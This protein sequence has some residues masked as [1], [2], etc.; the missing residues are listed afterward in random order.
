MNFKLRGPIN[1][2]LT[3]EEQI[4]MNR[5]VPV[6]KMKKLLNT[7]DNDIN[8]PLLFGKE[9]MAVAAKRIISAIVNN[10]DTLIIVDADCDGYTSAAIL[11]N[12][13]HDLAPVWTENHIKWFIHSGKQHGMGDVDLNLYDV[14]LIL[15]PDAGSNDYEHHADA[16]ARGM[17]VIILDHH[18]AEKI[19]D[20]AIVINNQLSDYPNKELSGAGVTWQFC[21]YIDSINNT[22]FAKDYIDLCALGNCADMMSMQSIETKHLILS[23]FRLDNIKNPF[24]FEMAKK[25]AHSLG[26]HITPIGAAFYI[27]PFI[28]AMVRSGEADEKEMLFQSMLKFKAFTQIP[29]GKRGC[30]GQMARLVD[31]AVRIATNVK[32][33]QTRNETAGMDLVE[34]LIEKNDMMAHK[35]LLFLLKPGDIDKNIAGLVANKIMA[36]Y[37]RPCCMLT[38][39]GDT[40]AGSARGCDA[41]DVTN[42]KD[43]CESTGLT[44]YAQGHQGAF[45]ISLDIANINNFVNSTDEILKDMP[46]EPV[47][48]VD[49]LYDQNNV[50]T[51]AIAKISA[52][53]DIWGR[54]L[55]ESYVG[56]QEIKLEPSMVTM[57]AR[58]TMK[59]SLP[60]ITLIQF[61]TKEE[62]YNELTRSGV[63]I[64]VYGKP[65]INEYNGRVYPQILIKAID[66]VK[67]SEEPSA[68]AFMF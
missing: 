32:N 3:T 61:N 9:V 52:L 46:D 42:F 5:G 37:Q 1:P 31:E 17:D 29:S 39:S 14:K 22:D 26:S 25:N 8:S 23:G 28:N 36:K 20:D 11:L 65:S 24:I 51:L 35:V 54:G 60:G 53:E 34:G 33:R 63:V 47:Y 19:S 15:I 55:E 58:G 38:L 13:L 7:T 45:G 2:F 56:V 10:E 49:F 40:Y 68:T 50:D 66:I 59:I 67:A 18:E 12:Y 41:V 57:M 27:A 62:E 48:Y 4:F 64:D 44:N 30:K 43:I 6:S 21:R 16:R